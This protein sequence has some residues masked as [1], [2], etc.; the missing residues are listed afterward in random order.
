M[1]QEY[2]VSTWGND[3]NIGN[4]KA[5]FRTINRAAQAAT[6]G[7]TVIVHEGTYR[8]WVKPINGGLNETCR[9]TYQAAPGEQVIIK[10]SE[11]MTG[12]RN[13]GDGLWMVK[14]PNKFFGDYN[15]YLE[16][17]DGDWLIWPADP[18]LHTGEVYMNGAALREV[19]TFDGA[20][21]KN[22]WYTEAGIDVTVIYA[23]FGKLDPNQELTEINVRKCCFYPEHSHIDYITVKGFEMAHAASPWAPPTAEQFG[24]LG[25]HWSKGW[26]IENNI[27][28]DAKCSAVSL[29]KNAS[30]GHNLSN[31]FHKKS[32]YIYQ[33]EAVLRAKKQGWSRETVGSH[34]VRNNLIYN[35]G[36]NAVVGHMC[37]AFSQ[38]YG[39]HIFNIGNHNQFFGWEIAGIKFHAAI[40]TQIHDNY[41]H[42]CQRGIWIDWQGQGIRIS[43]NIFHKNELDLFVEMVHGPYLVD[44]NIF[45]SDHNFS[46]VSQGGAFVHNLFL[47][48]LRQKPE[49]ERSPFYHFPHSTD[50]AG[51]SVIFGCDD[52]YFQNIFTGTKVSEQLENGAERSGNGTDHYNGCPVSLEEYVEESKKDRK[53]D[54]EKELRQIQPVYI[55]GNCYFGAAKA[56]HREEHNVI[57]EFDSNPQITEENGDV[58]LAIEIPNEAVTIP[59]KIITTQDLGTPRIVEAVY[60]NP[61]GTPVAIDT[62]FHGIYRKCAPMPG[63]FETLKQGHNKILLWKQNNGKK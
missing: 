21:E 10:G 59:T 27:F 54:H 8:E 41:I 52:R 26:V 31:R 37:S 38:V 61:D 28:H 15:P 32:G 39:N 47:G 6:Y 7:D 17:I 34:I 3:K 51:I 16:V 2:H 1:H 25:V 50:I 13:C 4:A 30:T 19:L 35:C 60:E 14:I 56:F 24:M 40:D 55:D 20:L 46:S 36:Q 22:T 53:A 62:D 42:D 49:L 33:A 43:R 48:A 23:N 29:G 44:N 58:Y 11:Q 9:I 12:W 63:P 18:F 45:A 5:P 57:V